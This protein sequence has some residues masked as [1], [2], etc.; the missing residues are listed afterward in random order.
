MDA[1]IVIT[2][3]NPLAQLHAHTVA[4]EALENL[5]GL[6]MQLIWSVGTCALPHGLVTAASHYKLEAT[7][8]VYII[9]NCFFKNIIHSMLYFC[10]FILSAP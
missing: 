9:T 1:F 2:V 7:T 3:L 8:T 4:A 10:R 5:G 6:A